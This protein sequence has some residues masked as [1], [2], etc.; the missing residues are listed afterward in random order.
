[1]LFSCGE[2]VVKSSC[3]INKDEF[4]PYICMETSRS[5]GRCMNSDKNKVISG[6]AC[7]EGYLA[8]C[9]YMAGKLF[10]YNSSSGDLPD[11]EEKCAEMAGVLYRADTD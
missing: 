4:S 7:P 3:I 10:Y 1:M 9:R 8:Y 11:L 6:T 2:E 5:E